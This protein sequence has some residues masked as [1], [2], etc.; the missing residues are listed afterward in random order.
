M[1]EDCR[2]CGKHKDESSPYCSALPH[3]PPPSGDLTINAPPG[4]PLGIPTFPWLWREEAK[5]TEI[6]A[7]YLSITE[8]EK[9]WCEKFIRDRAAAPVRQ[10]P[11]PPCPESVEFYLSG[12]ERE[13]GN[14]SEEEYQPFALRIW[15]LTPKLAVS[16]TQ[17]EVVHQIC[18]HTIDSLS[19]MTLADRC[20]LRAKLAVPAR[21]VGEYRVA[22]PTADHYAL[23][24]LPLAELHLLRDRVN[25]AIYD[26]ER[27]H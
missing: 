13:L 14:L 21:S 18:N 19:K 12:L 7:K 25:E 23:S 10:Q 24:H 11:P 6:V 22:G 17:A 27:S 1:A 16:R 3:P 15:E 4:L 2:T 8:E 5:E 9:G 26:A 20:R